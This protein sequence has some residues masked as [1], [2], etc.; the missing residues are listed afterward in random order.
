MLR[1]SRT[2]L[3][4]MQ[5]SM[6][7]QEALVELP[8][9]NIRMCFKIAGPIEPHVLEA[10]L[11][12]VAR[13]HDVL[14]SHYSSAGAQPCPP[15][16]KPELVTRTSAGG[17]EVSLICD[18][19]WKRP[20]DL[21]S[22]LPIRAMLVSASAAEHHLGLCVHHIAADSWSLRL[23]LEE[24][25]QTYGRFLHGEPCAD[26]STAPSYFEPAL[27][28]RNTTQDVDWWRERLAGIAGQPYPKT[29]PFDGATNA[30]VISVDL[31]V[32]AFASR[33]VRELAGV[34][35]VSPAVV[36]F[37]A[38]SSVAAECQGLHE[39]VVGLLVAL[40]DTRRLQMTVGP[41][42]NTLPIRTSWPISC[43]STELISA[44][45][46]A[47]NLALTHKH[48]PYSRILKACAAERT[49]RTAPIFLHLVN[50]DN[51]SYRLRLPGTRCVQV[52][53]SPEW[54]IFPALWEFSWRSIG[55]VRGVLRASAD[56]FTA[57]QAAV[58]AD[59]F[60]SKLLKLAS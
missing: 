20:F 59:M 16:S 5:K 30:D 25:G 44:H 49:E 38:V 23:F 46:S 56:A 31:D 10:A 2:P 29:W 4:F 1:H 24:L 50:I 54:A 47:I 37:T 39:A 45:E 41:L 35:Q 28:E 3:S 7:A 34:A 18:E 8:V 55:N 17:D 15:H 32:D 58:L 48:V 33:A 12:R 43:S 42:L 26:D 19:L 36:L 52:P 40:R 13:R 6:L 21:A 51:E 27:Q 60:R 11:C 53:T 57:D 22:E 14:C 9:Y